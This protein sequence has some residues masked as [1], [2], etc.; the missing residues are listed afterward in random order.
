MIRG[1][2]TDSNLELNIEH[3]KNYNRMKK[4]WLKILLVVLDIKAIIIYLKWGMF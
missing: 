1:Y 2:A 3:G 4:K